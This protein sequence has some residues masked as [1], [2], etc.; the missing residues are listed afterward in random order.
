M[1]NTT[2][3]SI[4]WIR[5]AIFSLGLAVLAGLAVYI[6]TGH[7]AIS[8]ALVAVLFSCFFLILAIDLL[9][10]RHKGRGVR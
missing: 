4:P 3:N 8:L 10:S 5:V 9:W 6:R 7:F 2:T 1:S